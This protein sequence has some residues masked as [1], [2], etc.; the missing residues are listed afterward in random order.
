M[1]FSLASPGIQTNEYDVTTI[2]P[3]IA[4]SPACVAGLFRWGPVNVPTLVSSE[5]NLVQVFQSPTNFN[6]ETFFVSADYL[7][8]A[9]ALY[10]TRTVNSVD[11]FSAVAT[12]ANGTVTSN[13]S[14]TIFNT[15][16]Y[17]VKIGNAGYSSS[18]QL[19]YIAKYPGAIGSS[20]KISVCD[21]PNAYFQNCFS[22]FHS[23]GDGTA[24][25]NVAAI[26]VGFNIGSNTFTLST[27]SANDAVAIAAVFTV[28]DIL[29]VGNTTLGFNS[30]KLSNTVISGSNVTLQTLSP[31]SLASALVANSVAAANGSA[32][33]NR[34]WEYYKNV[35]KSPNTTPYVQTVA[36][37]AS[38]DEIHIV[39]V[40]QDGLFSTVPGQ[41]LEVWQSLSRAT[42]AQNQNGQNNYYAE[43]INQSSKFAWWAN[44]R[45]TNYSNTSIN[46]TTLNTNPLSMAFSGGTDGAGTEANVSPGVIANGYNMYISPEDISVGLVLA[47]KPIGGVSNTQNGNYIINNIVTVRR[48]CVVFISPDGVINN[49]GNEASYIVNSFCPQLTPTSYAFIDSGYKYRYDKYNNIYRYTPLNGDMAG[50]CS[51]TD[52][53]RAPWYSPAGM[54]RGQIKNV[55]KLAYNPKQ[56]DRDTLY[57]ASVN[58]VISSPSLGTLLYGDITFLQQPSAFSRINVRRLFIVLEKAISVAAKSLLFEFNDAFTQAQ[59]I[60]M[61]DPYLRQVMGQRGIYDYQIVCDDTNNTPQVVDNNQFIG[62][63]YIKPARSINFIQ[64]NFVAVATEVAFSEIVGT[65]GF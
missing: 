60:N 31:Y 45:L 19:L 57:Q 49:A 5:P 38:G 12:S 7:A 29:S 34:Y 64:L 53:V 63:I 21:S 30:M 40:D 52:S 13:A 62:D 1:S 16:D 17:Q 23:A 33:F 2:V 51:Y 9:S 26:T 39:I 36:P 8:Y 65:L 27:G 14:V 3:A 46:M 48:D 10:V 6:A 11:T 54:N 20:L 28:G 22:A 37:A 43:V 25:V 41:V 42:D 32:T 44:D 18:E 56:T 55:I 4:S 61:V 59:F 50:C 15:S 35:S 58:P 47:G 24:S